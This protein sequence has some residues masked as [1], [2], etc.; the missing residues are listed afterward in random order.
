M[1]N[2]ATVYETVVEAVSHDFGLTAKHCDVF[3]RDFFLWDDMFSWDE[4]NQPNPSYAVQEAAK[5]FF[6]RGSWWLRWKYRPESYPKGS[7]LLNGVSVVPKRTSRGNR[8]YTLADIERMAHSLAE[9][10]SIGGEKLAQI[11]TLLLVQ[12]AMYGI[13]DPKKG[14]S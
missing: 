5:M 9:Q 6:A 8:Y 14:Q 12:A 1:S 3:D 2:F 10:G 11:I 7:F 4:N 13:L